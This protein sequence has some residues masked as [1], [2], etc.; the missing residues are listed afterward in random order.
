MVWNGD[1]EEENG[2]IGGRGDGAEMMGDEEL[3][4]Q[5]RMLEGKGSSST[6]KQEQRNNR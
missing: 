2:D 4:R 3:D 5:I 6:S 1:D